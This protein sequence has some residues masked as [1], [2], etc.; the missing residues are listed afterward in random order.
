MLDLNSL[1]PPNS[2]LIVTKAV[3]IN[4]AGQIAATGTLN[5]QPHALLLNPS[6]QQPKA[7]LP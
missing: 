5:G 1:L 6:R 4:D 3:G 2:G 7:I